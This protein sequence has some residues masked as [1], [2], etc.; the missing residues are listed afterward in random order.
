MTSHASHLALCLL[1]PLVVSTSLS[2]T[3]PPQAVR[4]DLRDLILSSH[5]EWPSDFEGNYGGLFIRQ[6]WHCAGS[7]RCA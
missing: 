4:R 3:S 7:Y 2:A 5:P 6:A 1:H